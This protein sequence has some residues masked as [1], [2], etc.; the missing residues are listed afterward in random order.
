MAIVIDASVGT[1]TANSYVTMAEADDYFNS[2]IAS[3]SWDSATN[4]KALLVHSSRNL[5]SFMTWYGDRLA[6]E[7]TQSMDWPRINVLNVDSDIV[8]Q[9]LKN[10]VLELA[11][12]LALNGTSVDLAEASKIKVG[13]LTIDLDSDGA[14]YL[15][16]PQISRI[17]SSLGIPKSLPKNGVS[18]VALSR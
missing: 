17:L 3:Q 18:V 12:F 11:S 13:P 16:P 7:T 2:H 10:A 9:R 6:D 1:S 4:R 5:D 15:L 8:P 14:G